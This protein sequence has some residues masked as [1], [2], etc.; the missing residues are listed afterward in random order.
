LLFA[1][2]SSSKNK[3]GGCSDLLCDVQSELY[4][5]FSACGKLTLTVQ[6]NHRADFHGFIYERHNAAVRSRSVFLLVFFWFT[7][8]LRPLMAFRPQKSERR[9]MISPPLQKKLVEI[10]LLFLPEQDC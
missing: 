5:F 10:I 8:G 1:E 3:V 9:R 4:D 6:L 7:P 2:S